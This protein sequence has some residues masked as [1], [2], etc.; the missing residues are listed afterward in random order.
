MF[1]TVYFKFQYS[2]INIGEVTASKGFWR[3][4]VKYVIAKHRVVQKFGGVQ[5]TIESCSNKLVPC[6]YSVHLES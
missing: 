5:P 4:S 6:L 1:A 3:K 2:S